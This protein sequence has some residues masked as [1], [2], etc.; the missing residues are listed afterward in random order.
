MFATP[1]LPFSGA[2]Y[3]ADSARPTTELLE[4]KGM[5]YQVLGGGRIEHDEAHHEVFIYGHSYGFPWQVCQC[6]GWVTRL[7][8]HCRIHRPCQ[9]RPQTGG[10]L[11]MFGSNVIASRPLLN[12]R[13][14][15]KRGLIG[16]TGSPSGSC[17]LLF[18]GDSQGK[19]RGDITAEVCKAAL[20]EYTV[21]WSSEGY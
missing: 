18:F 9:I 16:S 3:H 2:Q 11:P 21:R 6:S 10:S 20:P 12:E 1:R 14:N 15:D 8:S 5:S 17:S 13:Q 7:W 4:A 19:N